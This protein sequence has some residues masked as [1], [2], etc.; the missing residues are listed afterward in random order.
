MPQLYRSFGY[1]TG[2]RCDQ[3]AARIVKVGLTQLRGGFHHV[4]VR[5]HHG[6]ID[7]RAGGFQLLFGIGQGVLRRGQVVAGMGQL[8]LGNRPAGS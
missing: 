1:V 7:Q 8:F 4:R 3:S 2:D 6:V 5:R